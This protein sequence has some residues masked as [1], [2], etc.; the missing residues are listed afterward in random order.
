MQSFIIQQKIR[1]LVNQYGVY[2]VNEDGTQ[3]QIFAFAQQKRFAFKERFDLYTD[4]SK[5]TLNFTIQARQVMDFGARYD[6]KAADGTHLGTI[7]KD[8]KSSLLRSTWLVFAPG[9]EQAPLLKIQERSKGLAIARRIWGFLPY[10]GDIP[11]FLKYHFDFLDPDN[12]QIAATLDKTATFRDFYRLD[13]VGGAAEA[14]DP[15]VLIAVGVML[16]AL[17]SR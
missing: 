16:D 14:A 17:Q 6:V 12:G 9:E 3:G 11:F 1:A 10:I 7:G 15:R 4:E 2:T 8:F 5:Q 13:I